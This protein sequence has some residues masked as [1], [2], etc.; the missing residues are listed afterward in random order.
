M[1]DSPDISIIIPVYNAEKTLNKCIDSI[2]LQSFSNWELL[3][4]ND[5]SKDKSGDICEEYAKKDSRIKV[6][7][8]ENGGV[9][10]ARNLGL[11]NAKGKWITFV[12]VDD[13]I[14]GD[15]LQIDYFPY[16]EDLILYPYYIE[17]KSI[18]TFFPIVHDKRISLKEKELGFWLSENLHKGILRTVW[19][20]LFKASLLQNLRFDNN[21]RL[22]E[23]NL[24]LIEYLNR[25]SSCR[26]VDTP[27]YV[28]TG[29]NKY[30]LRV[31]DAIYI[32]S[33]L[34][35]AYKRLNVKAGVFERETFCAYKSFCQ[36]NIYLNPASWFLD[37]SVQHVY[38][39]IKGN[40][41]FNYR[42]RY[43]ILF[44]ISIWKKY[45]AIIYSGK[46]L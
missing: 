18:R 44:L 19:S 11:D 12:D 1:K 13:W 25:I 42:F 16:K 27:F 37:K 39:E 45:F 5:G 41:G 32:M 20:K 26:F 43:M 6:F 23:D 24:F 40:L 3:L 14:I 8:K 28:Y 33:R 34:F 9:S 29:V 17:A 4:I 10:S 22:G 7:H 36:Q 38:R 21:I 46:V 15:F 2:F 31:D 35:S 30:Q